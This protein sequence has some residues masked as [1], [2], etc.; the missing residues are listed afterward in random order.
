[1]FFFS[2]TTFFCK[3]FYYYICHSSEYREKYSAFVDSFP[4][5][6]VGIALQNL[7]NYVVFLFQFLR[8][9]KFFIEIAMYIYP[10]LLGV[11]D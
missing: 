8:Q 2:V 6:N 3:K 9:N 10:F 5:G 7:V 11:I 4:Q 1:M